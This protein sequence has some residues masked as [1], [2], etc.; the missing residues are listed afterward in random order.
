M[1]EVFNDR[2]RFLARASVSD[3]A[4]PGVPVAWGVWWHKLTQ[5]GRNVNA[6]TSQALTDLGRGPTFYDCLV[7]LRPAP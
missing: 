5:G 2:G 7:E 6:V 4:R 3:R 1:V